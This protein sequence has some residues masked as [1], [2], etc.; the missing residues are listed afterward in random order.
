MQL[1]QYEIFII[2]TCDY[3]L[4]SEP[5]H[6]V[7]LNIFNVVSLSTLVQEIQQLNKVVDGQQ[8]DKTAMFKIFNICG[9]MKL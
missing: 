9:L 3:S 5:H 4:L 1:K 2:K 8:T 6:M 7:R